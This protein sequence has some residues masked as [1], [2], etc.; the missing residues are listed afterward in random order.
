MLRQGAED[1]L[2]GFL[3]RREVAAFAKAQHHVEKA[4][5]RSTIGNGIVLAADGANA[6]AAERENAGLDRGLAHDLDDLAHVEAGVEVGGIFDREMR[7]GEITPRLIS[8]EVAAHGSIR[9]IIGL[10]RVTLAGLDRADEGPREHDL[11]WF[12]RKSQR[13]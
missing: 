4:V 8:S 10:D 11:A 3:A 7:H 1:V 5:I 2:A 9:T 6:D 12:Q 13:R